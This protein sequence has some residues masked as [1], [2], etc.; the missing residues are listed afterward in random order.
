MAVRDPV[1]D[2][3]PALLGWWLGRL[4]TLFPTREKYPGSSQL[5]AVPV[6]PSEHVLCDRKFWLND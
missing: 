4:T 5:A 3:Y 2:R 1:E 6:S